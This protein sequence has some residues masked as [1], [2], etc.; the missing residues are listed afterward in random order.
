MIEIK[1]DIVGGSLA[2]LSSA[3]S[4]KKYDKSIKVRVFEKYKKI[5]YNAE[6]RRCGEA[7]SLMPECK[8]WIPPKKSIFNEIRIGETVVGSEKHSIK[9]KPNITGFMLNR[10]EFIFQLGKKAEEL[11]AELI[12]D[13]KVKSLNELDGEYIIDASGCP[14]TI[15]KII[16]KDRGIKGSTY[17]QTLENSNAF[18]PDRLKVI[19]TGDPGYF[20]IFPR[21]PEKRE[22][23][24]GFG[25][26]IKTDKNLKKEL[27]KFKKEHNITGKINHVTGGLIP[28]GLQ[29]PLMY[30]NILF[31]G[32]AGVGA[33]TFTGQGIYRALIS[34]DYAAKCI[35][36]GKAKKYPRMVVGA[37]IKWD[38]IGKIYLYP[39]FIFSKINQDL[40]LSYFK[41]FF[42]FNLSH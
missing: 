21:N 24:L 7:H 19:F 16:G 6:G 30:K 23:N 25:T 20:W 35:S 17:Q 38:T 28:L 41:Y 1:V 11:G 4:L 33:F 10:P 9:A 42:N 8:K 26:S 13:H 31:V 39:S 40:V 12:T 37:F 15:K 34:G 27:E 32:D 3:I 2:G 14:S 18:V 22:V 5:G 29:R 36:K